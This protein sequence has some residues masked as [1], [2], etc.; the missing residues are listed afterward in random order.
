MKHLNI[1]FWYS[2][3]KNEKKIQAMGKKKGKYFFQ[4][5]FKIGYRYFSLKRHKKKEI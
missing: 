2:F 4:E 5:I 3:D 1:G